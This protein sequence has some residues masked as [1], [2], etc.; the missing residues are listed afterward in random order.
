V[1]PPLAA[2]IVNVTVTT[3]GG[4]SNARQFTSVVRPVGDDNIESARDS[5]SGGRAEAFQYTA[6]ASGTVNTISIFI[7]SGNNASRVVVGLY[8]NNG[9]I[10]SPGTLLTQATILNP[11]AGAWNTVSVSSVSVTSGV[12]YWIAVLSPASKGIVRFRD[13]V[14]GGSSQQ[15]SQSSLSTLPSTWTTGTRESRSPM[16][17]YAQ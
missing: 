15:S 1:A 5:N 10:N 7:D 9:T 12:K 4:T 17:A 13:V 11:V 3:V 2:G 14:S 8:T 16:S 6:N